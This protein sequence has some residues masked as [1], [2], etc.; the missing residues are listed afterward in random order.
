MLE[1]L[2][3]PTGFK[4]NLIEPLPVIVTERI[5]LETVLRNLIANAVKHYDRD[6][7]TGCVK[8]ACQDRDEFLEFSVTD[9]GPGIDPLF[10][11]RI[12][13]IF[14]TLQPR[15][16]VEGSG[17]GLSIVKRTVESRGGQ[18]QV[19]SRPGAGATFSF[20]WPKITPAVTD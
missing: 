13:E 3:I 14:Q 6:P 11:R 7:A 9:N 8:I 10:H 5:P 4:V 20:T 2:A 1:L 16:L 15:D 12:F 17:I 19:A 18:V